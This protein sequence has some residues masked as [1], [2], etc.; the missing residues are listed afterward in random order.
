MD[1]RISRKDEH[2]QLAL[3]HPDIEVSDFDSI[4]LIHQSLP[5]CDVKDVKLNT[6]ISSINLNTP[7]YIN[8][9][10]GGTKWAQEI[11]EKLAIVARETD[12]AM[13]VGSMHAALKS[14]QLKETYSVVRNIYKG[15]LFSNVGADVPLEFAKRAVDFLQADA[16][17][18]HV[19]APQELIMP[20]G[21]RIFSNW[22]SHIESIVNEIDVP[23][24]VKEVGFGMSRETMLKLKSVG[25]TT[26]DVSGSG[27]TNFIHIEN[28]RRTLKDF[29]YMKGWGQTTAISLLESKGTGLEVLASG[30]IRNPLDALKCMVLGAQAVGIS[31]PI[32]LKV[33]NEG[34]EDAIKYINDFK[35]HLIILLTMSGKTCIQDLT[36]INYILKG[37]VWSW[38]QQRNENMGWN[39]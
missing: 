11:N 35:E 18:I 34:I 12:S 8:A 24:I 2:I 14:N 36:S 39:T 13:A 31:R 19:N 16:L 29:S 33:E 27:G 17:Q 1:K 32:L 10:T 3:G 7:I 30:G 22:L 26:I 6:R 9:M 28:E 4:D 38:Y 15:P 37:D 5:E 23:I 20:E 25:V 21:N